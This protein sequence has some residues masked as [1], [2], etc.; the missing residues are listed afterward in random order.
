M[1]VEEIMKRPVVS[2][3]LDDTLNTAARLMWENDCGA[4]PV[5]DEGGAAVGMITDRDIC[6][7]SYTQGC[8]LAA[9]PV[10]TAMS[11]ELFACRPGDPATEAERL[12]QKKQVRRLPVVDPEGRPVGIVS[13]NDLVR[14]AARATSRKTGGAAVDVLRT[15]ASIGEPR[16]RSLHAA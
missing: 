5:L 10:R 1:R 11:R 15:L 9:I 8:A 2:C 3:S 4:L 14:E 7:A 6:M 12:M 13:L 16:A